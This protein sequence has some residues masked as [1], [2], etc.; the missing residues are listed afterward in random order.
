MPG[1]WAHTLYVL[2]MTP[3]DMFSV[4]FVMKE[5][6]FK[7]RQEVAVAIAKELKFQVMW[8][9]SLCS[10]ELSVKMSDLQGKNWNHS[11]T[12]EKGHSV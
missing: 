4:G 8:G 11:V 7:L 10:L 9:D 1:N 3:E 5:P 6:S 12:T 2:I